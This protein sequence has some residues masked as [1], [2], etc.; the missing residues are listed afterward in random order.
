MGKDGTMGAWE[1]LLIERM[2]L[3]EAT[4]SCATQ[5]HLVASFADKVLNEADEGLKHRFA[6]FATRVEANLSHEIEHGDRSLL[7][8]DHPLNIKLT[9]LGLRDTR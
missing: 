6:E 2:D 7:V 3:A 9:E 5:K 4:G 1:E 8:Q